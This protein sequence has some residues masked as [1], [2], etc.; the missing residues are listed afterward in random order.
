[1]I[2]KDGVAICECGLRAVLSY[3]IGWKCPE[4]GVT[5]QKEATNVA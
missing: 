4:H 5:G 1:M 2:Y 3:A